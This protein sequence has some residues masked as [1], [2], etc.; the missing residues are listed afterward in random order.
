M[1]YLTGTCDKALLTRKASHSL[2]VMV[3]TLIP[4]IGGCSLTPGQSSV[5]APQSTV[6]AP[7]VGQGG[8][9]TWLESARL[10]YARHSAAATPGSSLPAGWNNGPSSTAAVQVLGVRYPHPEG[11]KDR[12]RVELVLGEVSHSEG[13]NSW[14][15]RLGRALSETLP[16]MS[17]GEG[18]HQAKAMDLPVAELQQLV[19]DA[20]GSTSRAI[21]EAPGKTLAQY[22]TE[23][24]GR[25]NVV[26]TAPIPALESLVARV[27]RDGKLIAYSGRADQLL[28]GLQQAAPNARVNHSHSLSTAGPTGVASLIP[29]PPIPTTY[30]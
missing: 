2:G 16:G 3:L 21:Y 30:R 19:V 15:R 29:L 20:S 24:N 13:T 6:I 5:V 7:T 10:T 22:A 23:I 18:I 17:W 11:H 25:H 26:Q 1:A 4:V 9:A 27:A 14:H 28:S 8:A 12:A